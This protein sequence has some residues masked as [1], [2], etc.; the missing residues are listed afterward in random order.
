MPCAQKSLFW[1][2]QGM[3]SLTHALLSLASSIPGVVV[4]AAR[5]L[6]NISQYWARLRRICYRDA[7]EINEG[8]PWGV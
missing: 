8:A 7:S 5:I 1:C 2:S 3:G 6:D 4:P